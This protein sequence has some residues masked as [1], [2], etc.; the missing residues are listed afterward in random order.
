M[1]TAAYTAYETLN[2][3]AVKVLRTGNYEALRAWADKKEA[4]LFAKTQVFSPIWVD[5]VI[6]SVAR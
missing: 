1:N 5:A 2:G 6:H 4:A 3:K